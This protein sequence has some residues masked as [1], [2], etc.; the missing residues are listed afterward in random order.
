MTQA[1]LPWPGITPGSG[2]DAGPY[3]AA[4]WWGAWVAAQAAGGL[5]VD[6]S[7]G[8][9][10]RTLAARANLGVYYAVP[11]QLEVTNPGAAAGT[12]QI[13]TGAALVDGQHFWNDAAITFTGIPINKANDLIVV[14]K[15]YSAATFTPGDSADA[16]EQVPPFTTRI[17]RLDIG[18]GDVFTQDTTRAT[19]W[20]I[21]LMDFSTDGAGAVTL[22][23]DDREYVD[24]E[25]KTIF[26]QSNGGV[27][28]S[29]S[30]AA[31][32][33][34]EGVVLIDTKDV[35]GFAHIITP[36]DFINEMTIEPVIIPS[37]TGNLYHNDSY[38]W[39]QCGE[40][41]T[42]HTLST[43]WLTTAVTNGQRN[44]ISIQTLSP[45]T[46]GDIITCELRRDATAGAD[47]INASAMLSGFQLSYF[48]WR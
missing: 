7:I 33:L 24:A 9:L 21:P 44:C 26:V 22:N 12:I 10:L 31:L 27:N 39:G 43:G 1:S 16:D 38:D 2:A 47:T 15:N 3:T 6:S 46:I 11:N 18:G 14:R 36:N 20:D 45:V 4:S 41:Y 19:Y 8:T 37:G 42:I 13:N 34:V 5:I 17:T 25:T 30:I 48:G 28:L 40:I 23:S 32:Y 35:Q 29:D